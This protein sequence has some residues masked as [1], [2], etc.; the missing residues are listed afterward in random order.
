[1]YIG[2]VFSF[3]AWDAPYCIY[4]SAT[5]KNTS[6]NTVTKTSSCHSCAP[7]SA[8]QRPAADALRPFW[9]CS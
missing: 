3:W 1:M 2:L 5:L 4:V 7:A 6:A 9:R 8:A